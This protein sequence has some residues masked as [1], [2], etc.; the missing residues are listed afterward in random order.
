MQGSIN[1]TFS[2]VSN[3]GKDVFLGNQFYSFD[4]RIDQYVVVWVVFD[5]FNVGIVDLREI[6][7]DI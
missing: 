3:V 4:I 2:V 1:R 7:P 5:G 6:V